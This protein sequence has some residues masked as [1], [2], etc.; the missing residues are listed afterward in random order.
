[1]RTFCQVCRGKGTVDDARISGPMAYCDQKG[2]TWPQM[3]CPNCS[4]AGLTGIP[5]DIADIFGKPQA[6]HDQPKATGTK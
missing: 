4:G 1:M 3:T 6:G 2:N 5:D